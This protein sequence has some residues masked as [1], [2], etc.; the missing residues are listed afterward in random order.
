MEKQVIVVICRE[1]GSMGHVIAEQLAEK[2]G[3]KLYDKALL[4]GM[5]EAHGMDP[6][7][8]HKYDEQRISPLLSKRIGNHSNSIEEILAEK[9]FE[10]ERELADSGES[11]VIVGR[12]ADY[13]LREYPNTL[14]IFVCGEYEAKLKRIM[15]VHNLG[16][17]AAAA[18][19]E[20]ENKKRRAYHNNHCDTKWGDSRSYDLTI[21]STKLGIEKTVEFLYD[22]VQLYMGKQ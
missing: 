9:I 6:E 11:F 14:R 10:F 5:A 2:M 18:K 17:K 7:I 12:C 3:V 21:N 1:Y 20:K 8:I 15:E 16:E 4:N 13:V 22:Y 19:L